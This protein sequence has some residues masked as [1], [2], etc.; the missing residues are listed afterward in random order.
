MKSSTLILGIFAILF[1]AMPNEGLVGT[2]SP[3][4]S[5]AKSALGL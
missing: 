5:G 3:Y 2:A 4:P 1:A